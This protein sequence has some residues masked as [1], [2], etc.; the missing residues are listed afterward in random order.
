M[1][2]GEFMDLHTSGVTAIR[3]YFDE[4]EKTSAMLAKCTPA[5]LPFTKRLALL[6]QEVIEN[7]AH[8]DYLAIKRR[9]HDAVRDGYED[10]DY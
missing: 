8:A 5:P 1:N 3:A 9:L 4:V 7:S 6:S 2:Y 10:S